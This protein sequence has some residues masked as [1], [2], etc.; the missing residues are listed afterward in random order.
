MKE[1]YIWQYTLTKKHFFILMIVPLLIGMMI[2]FTSL[3]HAEWNKKNDP[4]LVQSPQ[5]QGWTLM[6]E[7]DLSSYSMKLQDKNLKTASR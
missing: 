2:T 6:G 3:V 5:N 4:C 7:Q 1:K